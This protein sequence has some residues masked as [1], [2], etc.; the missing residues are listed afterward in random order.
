MEIKKC[1]HCG[2]DVILVKQ[3]LTTTSNCIYFLQC[4]NCEMEFRLRTDEP[5]CY[6]PFLNRPDPGPKDIIEKFNRRVT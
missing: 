1:P 4:T 6:V 3:L 2:G 5:P